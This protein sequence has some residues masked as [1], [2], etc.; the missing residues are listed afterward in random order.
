MTFSVVSR[1]WIAAAMMFGL[2]TLLGIRE[3]RLLP[4][5]RMHAHVLDVG[6]GDAILLV[7]PSGKHILIDGGPDT[8]VLRRL[9]K[10]MS[11]FD[12]TIELLVLTHPD[13]DHVVGL[14]EILRRYR[15]EQVLLTGVR[16]D[17]A[18]Y[19][20]FI[21]ELMRRRIPVLTPDPATDLDLGD[22]MVLD[23][24]WPDPTIFG[25]VPDDANDTSIVLRAMTND[26][27][28]LLTGDIEEKAEHAILRSGADLTADI[29]KV[30]H[31]GSR[32]SSSTGFLLATGPTLALVSA[33]KNS[34]FGHPHEDVL[35]RYAH[36][37]IPVRNTG[38]E[39]VL[40]TSSNITIA[41]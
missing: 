28:I 19:A 23:V 14:P 35:D 6:Q 1:W 11:F 5:G 4:D 10:H 3:L 36:F 21:D 33:A 30:P 12:R 27:R 32:T 39:G 13:A 16:H 37:G 41:K 18:K 31:H 9:G 29:L 20:W 25:T 7:S 22:G 15:V 40:S 24:I 17:T 38:W 2:A 34:Q 26:T 8:T